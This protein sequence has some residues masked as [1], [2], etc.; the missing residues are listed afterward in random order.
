MPMVE[1]PLEPFEQSVLD[2]IREEAG[3][4]LEGGRAQ[5]EITSEGDWTN[6]ELRPSNQGACQLTVSVNKQEHLPLPLALG[7]DQVVHEIEAPNGEDAVVRELRRLVGAV[8]RGRY[9]EEWRHLRRGRRSVAQF[10][11]TIHAEGGPIR[12]SYDGG[13]A[14]RPQKRRRYAPY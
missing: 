4:A 1:R 7:R 9:D 11:G 13:E 8:V 12:F 14:Y 3:G 5:L 6:F 2:A 10:V